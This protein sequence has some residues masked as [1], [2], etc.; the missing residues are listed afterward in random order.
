MDERS[1]HPSL[2]AYHSVWQLHVDVCSSPPELTKQLADPTMSP[3]D[4]TAPEQELR[5]RFQNA[6]M[7]PD[8]RFQ[9]AVSYSL[10]SPP[11]IG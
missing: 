2:R 6:A 4:P 8:Q 5:V 1:R 9:A 3:D 10:M 11:R 7:V